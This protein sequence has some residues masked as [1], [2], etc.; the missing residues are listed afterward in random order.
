MADK[1][2]VVIDL[3]SSSDESPRA[4]SG[5][6]EK[7]CSSPNK[8][9]SPKRNRPKRRRSETNICEDE[10][11]VVAHYVQNSRTKKRELIVDPKDPDGNAGSDEVVLVTPPKEPSGDQPS[12]PKRRRLVGQF[13]ESDAEVTCTAVETRKKV[14]VD[15]PHMRFQCEKIRFTPG[16]AHRFCS[17]CFCYIC[18]IP[19]K[20]CS[21]WFKHSYADDK[22]ATWR[23]MRQRR[24]QR[25]A[26]SE[27]NQSSAP[28]EVTVVLPTTAPAPNSRPLRQNSA[29]MTRREPSTQSESSE[30]NKTSSGSESEAFSYSE[31]RFPNPIAR[32]LS[33]NDLGI[34]LNP[35]AV[36]DLNEAM[37]SADGRE[38]PRRADSPSRKGYYRRCTRSMTRRSSGR[39]ISSRRSQNSNSGTTNSGQGTRA[40]RRAH[41]D[42][43]RKA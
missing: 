20:S 30:S 41:R 42:M 32:M 11:V 25:R 6:D 24:L 35:F 33:I 31:E 28:N 43:L 2:P 34:E 21:K 14:L 13:G 18:D 19:A 3:V 40:S 12:H 36:A 29:N 23:S 17:N 26:A 16:K 9:P 15:Y 7:N 8:S 38:R 22:T 1:D 5:D 37:P 27:R 39:N 4:P 10:V